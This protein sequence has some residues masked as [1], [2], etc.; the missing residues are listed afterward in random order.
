MSIVPEIV[1]G[2]TDLRKRQLIKIVESFGSVGCVKSELTRMSQSLRKDER[3]K[4]LDDLVEGG[5][6]AI[7]HE[8]ISKAVVTRYWTAP[9]YAENISA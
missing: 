5:E 4:L 6:I 7:K 3:N 8:K 2:E 9:N 1:T